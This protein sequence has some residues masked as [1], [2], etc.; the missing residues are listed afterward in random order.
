M[1]I[2]IDKRAIKAAIDAGETV[3]G[4]DLAIGKYTLI[5]K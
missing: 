3:P 4:A 2:S 1:E 5:R